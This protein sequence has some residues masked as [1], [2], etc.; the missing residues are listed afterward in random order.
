MSR[1][2]RSTAIAGMCVLA[3]G[4]SACGND[5]DPDPAGDTQSEGTE[6]DTSTE[7]EQDQ[8]AAD[9]SVAVLAGEWR[10]IPNVPTATIDLTIDAEGN[11]I[12]PGN[13][14]TI[15]LEGTVVLTEDGSYLF[16]LVNP[17]DAEQTVTFTAVDKGDPDNLVTFNMDGEETGTLSRIG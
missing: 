5:A 3:L 12:A 7:S 17:G 2:L 14:V 10:N 4:L 9:S 8:E 16:E 15:P 13:E 11:V 1:L 6:S